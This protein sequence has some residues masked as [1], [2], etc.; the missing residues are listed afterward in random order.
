MPYLCHISWL[1]WASC[2][3]RC[4]RNYTLGRIAAITDGASMQMLTMMPAV[5]LIIE[6]FGVDGDDDDNDEKDEDLE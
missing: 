2:S 5:F 3:L 4:C 6:Y 1:W